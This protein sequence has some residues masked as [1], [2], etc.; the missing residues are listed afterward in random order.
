MRIIIPLLFAFIFT[1]FLACNTG[2]GKKG[3]QTV[4]EKMVNIMYDM[5]FADA[6]LA[7]FSGE[8]RDSISALFWERMTQ[9]YGMSEKEIREEVAKLEGDPEKMKLVLGRVKEKADSIQ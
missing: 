6:L 7:E 9:L 1:L 8:Q 3:P 5:H 2:G 4:D